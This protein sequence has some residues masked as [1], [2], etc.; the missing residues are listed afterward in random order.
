MTNPIVPSTPLDGPLYNVV[1]I[2]PALAKEWLAQNT[3]NRNLRERVVTSYATDMRDG[4]WVEDGQS[5]KFSKGDIV[6]L[7]NPLITGKA[8]LDG[9]HR[10]S[11]IAESG[12]T[13]R[14]LVVS[15]LPDTTQETM[16]TG[17]KRS[18][19]DVLKLRGE[20][21]YVPLAA[22]LVR[23]HMWQEGARKSMR[24]ARPTHRQLLSLLEEHPEIRR[25]AEIGSRARNANRLSAS[26]AGLC[27][28]LF[29]QI[30][31]G[32][33]AFFFARLTDGAGLMIGDPI[34][35]LRRAAENAM[36]DK[37]RFREEHM[38]ALVIKA[39]NAY[40]EGRELQLLT[41]KAGG[42]R[43]EPYPEPK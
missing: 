10:L 40:R 43:P 33:C 37:A 38:T 18:L 36:T 6:L 25:S 5:I 14:M 39:W 31:Q 13:I 3:R 16:D 24:G 2:T 19:G 29:V 7:D 9:Q 11:A 20:S 42:A 41:Y 32:D 30:D 35:A 27:H 26:T 34:Y 1:D 17:A 21:H 8:L 12:M 15:N 22:V 28:W 4:N 23:V